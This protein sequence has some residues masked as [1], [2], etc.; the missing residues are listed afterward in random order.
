MAAEL[1]ELIARLRDGELTLDE[2]AHDAAARWV[3]RNVGASHLDE[4]DNSHLIG[5]VNQITVSVAV[6]EG[7]LSKDEEAAIY[8][9]LGVRLT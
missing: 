3:Q 1:D 9:A 8:S 2:F 7:E 5:S 6:R 4:V